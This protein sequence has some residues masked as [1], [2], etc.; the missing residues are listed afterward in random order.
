MEAGNNFAGCLKILENQG[1]EAEHRL[2]V[3][4]FG[5]IETYWNTSVVENL[6]IPKDI[7]K[8]SLIED[9][10]YVPKTSLI[11]E[12]EIELSEDELFFPNQDLEDNV[13]Q[14]KSEKVPPKKRKKTNQVEEE[15]SLNSG[16]CLND[17][18]LEEP[19]S[20]ENQFSLGV[21]VESILKKNQTETISGAEVKQELAT[22]RYCDFNLP[23]EKKEGK[24]FRS[25]IR[26][27][28]KT[29][30][31]VC[32]ICQK[33]HE[34][35]DE[36][37][38]H[39]N[40]LH[41]NVEGMVICGVNGCETKMQTLQTALAHVRL[42]HDGVERKKKNTP[43]KRGKRNRYSK[44]NLEVTSSHCKYCP[45]KLPTTN[46]KPKLRKHNKVE[47]FVCEIC[48][49]KHDNKDELDVHMNSLHKGIEGSLIC[50]VNGCERNM[51]RLQTVLE[52]VRI[53]HK[54]VADRICKDCNKPFL[55]LTQHKRLHHADPSSLKTCT[56]CGYTCLRKSGLLMHTKLRHPKSGS[57]SRKFQCA[58]CDFETSGL[59]QEE[60]YK[61][62][63]HKRI[64]QGGE[65]ICTMC[66]YKTEI[67]FS[68]KRH[69]AENHNIGHVFQCN[70]CD[71]KIGG[72]T[73]KAHMKTHMANHLNEKNFQCDQC[74]FAGNTKTSLER[75][76]KRHNSNSAKYHC[77]ECDYKS[78]DSGN[79][80][81]HRQVKHGS[82]VLSC[83]ECDYSTKSRRSLR[84]HSKK[85]LTNLTSLTYQEKLELK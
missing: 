7:L 64:H 68:L 5:C 74:E 82:V 67:P 42:D 17:G 59:S 51:Q 53:C 33:K 9:I 13:T 76:L 39:M 80:R 66:P 79:L 37:D 52:H 85:H 27:H 84:E 23:G 34:N 43:K 11:E 60:E 38:V 50:G 49:K 8:T 2:L 58:S 19:P 78:T 16:E 22:C 65:I 40:S 47:H 21:K 24:S 30:H 28:N 57:F 25:K 73:S 77:D 36:L 48:E 46:F 63:M 72:P 69:L 70:Q 32:E 18:D 83:E 1:F 3:E 12:G 26:K 61:L 81:A 14:V 10:K 75:H 55:T 35:K 4:L 15:T 41:K 20:L 71:Y 45:F 56:T 31:F 62:I 54:R 6:Y 44:A 29:E